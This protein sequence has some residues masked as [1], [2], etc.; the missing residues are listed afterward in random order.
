MMFLIKILF[1]KKTEGPQ[2]IPR[3]RTHTHTFTE[4]AGLDYIDAIGR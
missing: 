1:L 2:K 4:W 3:T